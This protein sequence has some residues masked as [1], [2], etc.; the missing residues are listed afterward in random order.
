MYP[1]TTRPSQAAAAGVWEKDQ[2]VSY[3]VEPGAKVPQAQNITVLWAR[4]T[5]P[6]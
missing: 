4:P 2:K 1:P 6:G 3:E 5:R